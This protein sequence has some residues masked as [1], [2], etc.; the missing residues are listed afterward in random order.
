MEIRFI[1]C[2]QFWFLGKRTLLLHHMVIVIVCGECG[3]SD[4]IA[5]EVF[6]LIGCNGL[7]GLEYFEKNYFLYLEYGLDIRIP[8]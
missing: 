3:V 5:W 2:R 7:G 1:S 4:F 6:R 8:I